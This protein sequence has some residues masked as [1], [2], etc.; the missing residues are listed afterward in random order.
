M[1]PQKKKKKE[2]EKQEEDASSAIFRLYTHPDPA[3]SRS[4]C[5][6][7]SQETKAEKRLA[8]TRGQ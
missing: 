4:T 6:A 1:K 5:Y 7:V 2:E 3:N 8:S